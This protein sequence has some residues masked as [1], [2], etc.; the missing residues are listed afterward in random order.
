MYYNILKEAIYLLTEYQIFNFPVPVHELE[1]LFTDK[2]IEI[3]F[4]KHISTPY[5]VCESI[6][7]PY[8]TTSCDYRHMLAHEAAH[9]F[10]HDPNYLFKNEIVAIKTEKQANAFAAYFLM[11]VYIF[12]E[13]ITYCS[14]DYELAKEFGVSECFVKFRK[15]L[16]EGLMHD[17][18]FDEYLKEA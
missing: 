6:T 12:E 3:L 4:S 8:C 9:V 18:Y 17:G 11:P 16:T 7:I 13:A 2:G 15:G 10:Y 14:C 1:Q 5:M